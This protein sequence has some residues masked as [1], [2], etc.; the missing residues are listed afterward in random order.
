MSDGHAGDA[1]YFH[2]YRFSDTAEEFVEQRKNIEL[3]DDQSL[4]PGSPE[5]AQAR[6]V[7][8]KNLDVLVGKKFGPGLPNLLKKF[9]CVIIRIDSISEAI[10][11]IRTNLDRIREEQEKGE[12]RQHLVLEP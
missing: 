12:D 1:R 10:Q 11:A 4:K 2:L 3:G 5:M 6:A 9:V 8:F 7:V